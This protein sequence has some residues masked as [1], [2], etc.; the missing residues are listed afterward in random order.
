M[1]TDWSAGADTASMLTAAAA[2]SSKMYAEAEVWADFASAVH[3]RAMLVN[4]IDVAGLPAEVAEHARRRVTL[5]LKAMVRAL[6]AAGEAAHSASV[7]LDALGD[8]IVA[9]RRG[10]PP[11]AT[12]RTGLS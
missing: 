10:R 6:Q 1:G 2:A 4:L 3:S 7:D 12:V 9:Y 8:E 5:G 11:V